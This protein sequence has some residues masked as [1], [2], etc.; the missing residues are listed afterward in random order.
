MTHCRCP[1]C[2]SP[3]VVS[4]KFDEE[5]LERATQIAQATQTLGSRRVTALAGLAA[6]AFRGLN[7]LR[8]DYAC[9]DCRY[10]FDG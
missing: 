8:K 10:R 6:L 2:Q 1:R 3:N 5:H 4:N 9:L 7:V